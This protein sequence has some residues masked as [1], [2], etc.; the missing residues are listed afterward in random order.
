MAQVVLNL[1]TQ[2]LLSIMKKLPAF[3]LPYFVLSSETQ[4]SKY[5]YFI[6]STTFPPSVFLCPFFPFPFP[7]SLLLPPSHSHSLQHSI[8]DESIDHGV[9]I[10]VDTNTWTCRVVVASKT[11]H[12][13]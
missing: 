12:N 8:I 6:P 3:H 5:M 4:C 13:K 2:Q 11:Y 7:L 1:P 9:A 10:V